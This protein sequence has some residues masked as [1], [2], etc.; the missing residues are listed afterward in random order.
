M[1]STESQ[2]RKLDVSD[3]PETTSNKE[4]KIEEEQSQ[5]DEVCFLQ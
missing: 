4:Q 5:V 3:E 1:S 2:K